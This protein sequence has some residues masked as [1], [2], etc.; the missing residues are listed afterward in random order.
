[1]SI[2]KPDTID[3]TLE[4]KLDAKALVQKHLC[5]KCKKHSAKALEWVAPNLRTFVESVE[6]DLEYFVKRVIPVGEK[7]DQEKEE[8]D[9]GKKG[10]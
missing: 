2:H 4:F 7:L 8:I 5:G 3:D 6:R 10:H 9:R 1:M